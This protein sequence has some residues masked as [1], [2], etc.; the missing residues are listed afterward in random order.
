M[1]LDPIQA[2]YRGRGRLRISLPSRIFILI[3]GLS[4]I[5]LTKQWTDALAVA[6]GATILNIVERT[7]LIR[8]LLPWLLTANFAL[9]YGVLA[10]F[11]V[12]SG[13]LWLPFLKSVGAT[14]ILSWF[15]GT[16][17]WAY[18]KRRYL[19]SSSLRWVAAWIDEGLLHG[20]L[21]LKNIEQ[22]FEV[23]FVRV[24]RAFIRPENVGLAVAGGVVN[25]FQKSIRLDD[26]RLLRQ[27]YQPTNEVDPADSEC[28]AT[29]RKLNDFSSS[30]SQK[31]LSV[32]HLYVNSPSGEPLLHDIHFS[33]NKGECLYLGGASGS[34]KTTLLRTICGLCPMHRGSITIGE[35]HRVRYRRAIGAVGFVPQNPDDSFFG[36]TPREDIIWGLRHRGLGHHEACN[37]AEQILADF[38][39]SHLIDR[40][41]SRLSFGEKKRVS[42]AAALVAP[43]QLLLLDEPT[44]GLD[45][46]AAKIL[47]DLVMA[48]VHARA[49]AVVWVSHD[50]QM[51]PTEIKTV[52]LLRDG[53]QIIADHPD[54]ALIARNLRK[55]GLL[56]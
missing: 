12:S 32:E 1:H 19:D 24:G 56:V 9:M 4:F 23:A 18:L 20:Q 34:G 28:C 11:G 46:V 15:G 54:Q 45:P 39:I 48:Q 55:A 22:R 13:A 29:D 36:S 5:L 38:G 7:G 8:S 53:Y 50:V 26:A 51:L 49:T 21:L 2:L 47:I 16:V 31:V 27:S 35:M 37:K 3:F 10:W 6:L 40:P 42:L 14:A 41:L 33:L 30:W 25:A 44:S 43:C 52:L 17:S